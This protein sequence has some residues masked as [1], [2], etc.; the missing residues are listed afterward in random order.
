M[1]LRTVRLI[2]IE[3]I[4]VTLELSN[5]NDMSYIEVLPMVDIESRLRHVMPSDGFK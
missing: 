1:P 2:C 4:L 3:E 5:V